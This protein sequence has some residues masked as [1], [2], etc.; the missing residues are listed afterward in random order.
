[1]KLKFKALAAAV[2]LAAFAGQ[3]SA[4]L[5]VP[6]TTL[7]TSDLIFIAMDQ[8][9]GNSFVYDL[10]APAALSSLN[11]NVTGAAWT[12]YLAAEGGSLA[13]TTWAL[14]YD[15]G[16]NA[17]SSLWGTTVTSGSA[18][19]SE[20]STKMSAGR[21]AFNNFLLSTAL[22]AAGDSAYTNAA[23]AGNYTNGM[24]NS[25]GGNAAGWTVDNTVGTAADFYT[26]NAATSAAGGTLLSP[27]TISFNGTTV[28]VAPVPEPETYG[29]LAAGLLML[30]AVA[31]RRKV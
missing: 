24:R 1:M 23:N 8:A 19:G 26:V 16:N 21:L 6:A 14:A 3:A 7:G 5:P 9:S 25:W 27:P 17:A 2:A 15:Q 11:L 10:G 31:R 4:A 18:I 20:T 30:G 22:T 28:A 29:M 13:N 12:S